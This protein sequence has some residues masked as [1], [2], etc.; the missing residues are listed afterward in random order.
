[1]VT[2]RSQAP[3]SGSADPVTAAVVASRLLPVIVLESANTAAPLA[4]ALIAGGLRCAEVT[5]RTAAAEAAIE[6]MAGDGRLL[7]G[8]GTVTN[9]DQV[10]RAIGAG[11]RFIVSP[12]FSAAVV[13]R[14]AQ[15]AVPVY[16]GIATATEIMAAL[17]E[18]L[19][20]VKFFPAQQLGG[21]ATLSALAAPF[22]GVR[23]I[24]T[25]GITAASLREYLGHASVAAVGGSW[26]VAPSLIAS[27]DWS[28]I[29]R[30]TAQAVAVATTVE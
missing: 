25:G 2:A 19:G 13:R 18:G 29:T 7:V 1:V 8:A 15:H 14:C 30:L 5:L 26:M 10:D 16:P 17:D 20:M 3:A 21:L 6:T 24:P 11:A 4:D 28:E 9:A 23:F 27:A 22:P 12:G